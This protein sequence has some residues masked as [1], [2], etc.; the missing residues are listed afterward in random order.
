V[1]QTASGRTLVVEVEFDSGP[2]AGL[3][4]TRAEIKVKAK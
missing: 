1:P 3:L 2:L 4:R